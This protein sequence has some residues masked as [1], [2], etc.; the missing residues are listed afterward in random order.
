MLYEDR[1]TS[2]GSD[3]VNLSLVDQVVVFA[4]ESSVGLLLN[5]EYHIPGLD[6]WRLI[7]LAL[8]VDLVSTA[9]TS[10]HM[11]MQD[12]SLDRRLLSVAGLALVLLPDDLALSITIGADSLEA[13]DHG[14]HLA[15]HRL[16]AVA[17]TASALL[18]SP[19][20]S[21]PAVALG[22]DD[23][24]LERKL[25]DLS[26]VNVFQGDFV[27][28]VDRAGLRRTSLLHTVPEHTT[29]TAAAAES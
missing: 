4:L 20:L 12:L 29:K 2:K 8:E 9:N 26:S 28:V 25:G 13:L 27:Y 23:G 14:A 24:F 22:A 5:L 11:D 10:V 3:Q 15:H 21:T 6:S 18:D 7:S 19:F 1:S 16:H 17:I